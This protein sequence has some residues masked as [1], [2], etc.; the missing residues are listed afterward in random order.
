[1]INAFATDPGFWGLI[2]GVLAIGFWWH[3]HHWNRFTAW[4]FAASSACFTLAIPTVLD[5]L[6]ALTA[7]KTR[8][9]VLVALDALVFVM[10]YLQ[11]GRTHKKSRAG[12]LFRRKGQPGGDAL[13]PV[14]RPNRYGEILTPLV[15]VMFGALVVITI[16]SWRI[17]SERVTVSALGTLKA[18]EQSAAAVNN[19]SAAHAIPA[20]ALQGTYIKLVVGFLVLA[21]VM[22]IA[23][24]R[25]GKRKGVSG[26]FRGRD[27]LPPMRAQRG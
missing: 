1:M 25:K 6:A 24:K 19:G 10:M 16:G 3:D 27:G 11:A 20:S 26:A 9:T 2:C 17:L 8:L 18:L 4:M 22:R 23:H 14:T 7:T 13:A 12:K 5:A 15:A 21:L